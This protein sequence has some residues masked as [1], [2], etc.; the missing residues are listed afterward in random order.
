[1]GT[2]LAARLWGWSFL[3]GICWLSQARGR[4]YHYTWQPWKNNQWRLK[5]LSYPKIYMSLLISGFPCTAPKSHCVSAELGLP[6]SLL[7]FHTQP[8]QVLAA[9]LSPVPH[10]GTPPYFQGNSSPQ[11]VTLS[12]LLRV[13]WK[14]KPLAWH[15]LP[16]LLCLEEREDIHNKFC[17]DRRKRWSLY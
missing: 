12:A 7:A 14:I 1:M 16:S 17:S 4:L 15:S 3:T 6:L 2:G 10:L 13:E 9:L 11:I 5:C 8:G